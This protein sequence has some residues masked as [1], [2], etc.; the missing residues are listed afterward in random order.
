MVECP[1]CFVL[2]PES[3]THFNN[4][5]MRW[6]CRTVNEKPNKS[7]P[8][9]ILDE[10]N[11]LINGDRRNDYGPP[12]ESFDRIARL[13]NAYLSKPFSGLSKYD[14]AMLLILL[15]IARAQQGI[16]TYPGVPQRDSLVDIAGYAGCADLMMQD[17]SD[18]D[19]F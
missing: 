19:P 14:V 11:E 1:N 3:K 15:K 12:S 9:S 6:D 16:I 13:W 18:E 17:H 10:A 7:A 2:V 5:F 4:L 8:K